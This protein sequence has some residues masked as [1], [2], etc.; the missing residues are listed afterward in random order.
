MMARRKLKGAVKSKTI[1]TNAAVIAAGA[2]DLLANNGMVLSALGPWG[3][4][5]LAVANMVL[6]NFTTESLSDKAL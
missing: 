3:P 5:G 1:L 6:R 4:L 2:V